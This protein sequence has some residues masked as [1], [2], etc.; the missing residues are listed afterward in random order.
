MNHL[1]TPGSQAFDDR[2][3]ARQLAALAH[4]VRIAILRHLNAN[5]GC[6]CKD[7]VCRVSMAQST[8]SQHL[9]ILV[10]AGL[11][12]SRPQGQRSCY[13]LD[14]AALRRLGQ[15]FSGLVEAC[16]CVEDRAGGD[17]GR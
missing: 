6:C 4:P 17:F 14:K 12:T 2:A 1:A 10:D 7:V 3:V 8:V 16:C 15:G 11:V 13:T 5:E 9:K